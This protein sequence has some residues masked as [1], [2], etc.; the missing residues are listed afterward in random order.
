MVGLAYLPWLTTL[1]PFSWR[2]SAGHWSL[3]YGALLSELPG[4]ILVAWLAPRVAYRRR[5]ALMLL[6]P[7]WGVRFAWVI[8][9]RLGK[10]PHADWPARTDAFPVHGRHAARIAVAV[11][12]YRSRRQ[13]RAGG[14]VLTKQEVSGR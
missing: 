13:R 14:P 4:V 5:D 12:S 10:L 3:D 1:Y 6:L 7:P 11:N 9:T 8:G 2:W